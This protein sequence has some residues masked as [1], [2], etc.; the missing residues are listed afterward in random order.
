MKNLPRKWNW[1]I[2]VEFVLDNIDTQKAGQVALRLVNDIDE[3]NY[4]THIKSTTVCS[5]TTMI[6]GE[7]LLDGYVDLL[8]VN[9]NELDKNKIADRIAQIVWGIF[10]F[11]Y[12]T[13]NF[14]LIY[15]RE[16]QYLRRKDDYNRLME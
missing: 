5:G 2:N 14:E 10:G 12:I 6:P 7:M 9:P 8:A 11:C 1:S 15:E 4:I 13:V 16:E 3:I